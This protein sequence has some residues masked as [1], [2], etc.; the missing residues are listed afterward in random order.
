M[1]EWVDLGGRL[2]R[3]WAG[4]GRYSVVVGDGHG[5]V[6]NFATLARLSPFLSP[7]PS[8]FP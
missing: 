2:G 6:H 5:W 3:R 8:P 4:G 7:F 1:A